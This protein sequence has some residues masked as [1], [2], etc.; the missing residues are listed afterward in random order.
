MKLQ[1]HHKSPKVDHRS[2]PPANREGSSAIGAPPDLPGH[3]PGGPASHL[4]NFQ[5]ALLGRIAPALTGIDEPIVR[6]DISG[7]TYTYNYN[8]QDG[9]GSVIAVTSSSGYVV[10][11]DT[12]GPYGETGTLTGNGARFTGRRLDPETGLYYY[13]ARYYSATLGRFLQTDPIGTRGGIN[14]YAYVGNDPLNLV[15]PMGTNSQLGAVASCSE[16]SVCI[17][18]QPNGGGGNLLAGGGI[19]LLVVANV[20]GFPEV[21]G[22]ELII[23]GIALLAVLNSTQSGTQTGSIATTN[24]DGPQYVVRAGAA[25][26]NSIQTGTA[27]TINGYGFSVQ[28]APDLS[29]EQLASGAP[30]IQNYGAYSY[31]TV[32]QLEE[33]PG[34]T[35]TWPTPGGGDNHGTVNVPY[36]PPPGIFD[37]ISGTFT[38]VRPNPFKN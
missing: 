5:T 20:A 22:G 18:N 26:A 35:V 31:T 6:I 14:L 29:P 4:G 11:S 24:D 8:H 9:L 17:A 21:E 7:S 37:L 3:A 19:G 12:Y 28:T 10:E 38:T 15:D 16:P 36:P 1:D 27:I 30:N 33:I 32:Q 2:A 25:A 34:V 13:R 23:G